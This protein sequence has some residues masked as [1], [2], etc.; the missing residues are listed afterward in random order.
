MFRINTYAATALIIIAAG[1][2]HNSNDSAANWVRYYAARPQ[3]AQADNSA[4]IQ[5]TIHPIAQKGRC[6]AASRAAST[7]RRRAKITVAGAAG[8]L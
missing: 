1:F 5:H 8:D 4:C 2:S 6:I 3:Q 7:L